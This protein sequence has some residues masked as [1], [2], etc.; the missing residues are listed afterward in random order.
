V[1]E[2][3]HPSLLALESLAVF[4]YVSLYFT[5]PYISLAP[6][7]RGDPVLVLPAF[8]GSDTSTSPLRAL[9]QWRGHATHGWGLGRNTGPHVRILDGM[10]RRLDAIHRE[11]G[12]TVSVV[13]WSLGGVYAREL[14]RV[15]TGAVRQ[16]ITLSSPFRLRTGDRTSATWLYDMVGPQDDPYF[17]QAEREEGRPGL[18]VPMTAIYTRTDG[19]VDWR[20][21]I[22]ADGSRCENIEVVGTHSGLGFNIAALV[23]IADRLAL[24]AGTWEP[25]RPPPAMR[26]LYGQSIPWQA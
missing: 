12:T 18:P 13:G 3:P 11:Y 10:R 22:E 9:L 23:A 16:V 19:I 26:H 4:E 8:T 15:D 21:C 17:D 1:I 7:G 20:A 2:A 24:P 14:A 5:A 25:F 6:P